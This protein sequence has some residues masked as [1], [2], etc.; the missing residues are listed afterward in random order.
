M[1]DCAAIRS[2]SGLVLIMLFTGSQAADLQ[3]GDPA[4]AFE[5][6]DQH[7]KVHRLSDYAGRWLV[8]YFYPRD[9]TPGCTAE[10]C[11]FRDDFVILKRMGVTVLGI[12]LDDVASH[13]TFAE[14]Y[15][16]PF[17]LL[18]DRK[19]EEARDYGSLWSLG[20]IKFAR[21]HT[22]I[23]DPQG[24]VAKIYRSVSP[25]KHSDEVIEDLQVLQP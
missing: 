20:P 9:D 7:G 13:Q 25:K 23:I 8:L 14:K 1:L 2:L 24:R 19:A 15:Q 12:S 4:P 21:R 18:A 16:L 5:L 6:R 17:A 3:A 22:F 10:A 11:E